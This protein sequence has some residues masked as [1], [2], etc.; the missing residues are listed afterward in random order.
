MKAADILRNKGDEVIG[1]RDTDTVRDAAKVMHVRRIGAVVVRCED[2]QVCGVLS[3]RDVTAQ[4]ALLGEGVLT[5]AVNDCMTR[6]IITALPDDTLDHLMELMTDRRIRHL[7]I[8]EDDTLL[9]I[10][11]IGDVVKYKIAEAEAEARA[12]HSYIAAGEGAINP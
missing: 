2:G 5:E 6:Q 11:S 1:V 4:L 8:V 10:V 9:G 7:P 3:E 12:M